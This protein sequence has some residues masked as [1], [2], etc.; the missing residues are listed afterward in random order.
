M[1]T[2]LS[3]AWLVT[4]LLLTSGAALAKRPT[5]VVAPLFSASSEE[6]QWIGGAL[7]ESLTARLLASGE[8]NVFS[9]RQW[10]AVLRERDIPAR[11]VHSDDDARAVGR[12]LGADQLVLGSFVAAWPDIRIR[13]QRLAKDGTKP[14]ATAE[15]SG[16]LEDLPKL[17]AELARALFAPSFA[18]AARHKAAPK[19]V[20][21]WRELSLC[22]DTLALQS[23]GPRAK[24][25]L[26][27]AL[28][29]EA[30]AH[31]AAAEKLDRAQVDAKS[32]RGLGLFLLGRPD[33]ARPL[34]EAALKARKAP[35]WPDLI[36]Y[37]VR[38]RAGDVDKGEAALT[39]AIRAR[40]GFLHAR[41]TLGE[42]LLERGRLDEAKRVF[43]ASLKE[44]ES[45][46]WI[47]V[48]LGK[49][50]SKQG[51]VDGA[52]VSTDKALDLVPG[53]AVILMEKASRQ[54]DGKRWKD[55]EST[56]REAMKQDP[57]LAA[58]YLRLGFVY[59]E[60]NQLDLAGPILEKALY[61]ADLASE[62][63][64]TGYAH[65]D[66]AKLAARQGDKARAL[67]ALKKAVTAGLADKERFTADPDLQEVVKDPAFAAM[68]EPPA[69]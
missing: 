51:D 26:P 20:Y 60:T 25:W 6:Y 13:A 15:V 64:V 37:F 56:L 65:Y 38:A 50:L 30:V 58:A 62:Q 23:I 43:E 69:R 3:L 17:E 32:F 7:S 48:Q 9:Q 12:Q 33:E 2:S 36:A 21:A 34:V 59:L 14:L 1:R 27:E 40:P 29:K 31:C 67:A 41:T 42:S 39:A 16:H 5:V 57:R 28:L 19:S 8:A 11:S 61:E 66:L 49:L 35:G 63:R 46:P 45:Q 68:F 24:P 53:D 10:A 47:L 4:T 52:V 54:I 44:A 55:A 22:R 18:K